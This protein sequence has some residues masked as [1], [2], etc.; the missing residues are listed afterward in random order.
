MKEADDEGP[1][2]DATSPSQLLVKHQDSD[3]EVEQD[4]SVYVQ[5]D[6]S[7]KDLQQGREK[8]YEEFLE[9]NPYEEVLDEQPAQEPMMQVPVALV[10]DLRL[11]SRTVIKKIPKKEGA[12]FKQSKAGVSK[13]E[14]FSQQTSPL[15]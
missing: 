2:G 10:T 3:E 1:F 11:M 6:F 14:I 15:V 13:A 9:F 5:D 8:A 12:L 4:E 7:F